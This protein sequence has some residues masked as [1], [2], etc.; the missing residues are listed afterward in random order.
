M[1][2]NPDPVLLRLGGLTIF[3]YG[4]LFTA[5]LFAT[6][7]MA[8]RY[9]VQRGLEEKHASNL[10]F[11]TIGGLFLGA[12]VLDVLVYNWS[13]FI[14]DPSI[15]LRFDRGLSS[16]GGGLGVVLAVILYAR[17]YKLDFHRVADCIMLAAVWMFAFIRTGNFINSEVVGMPTD[18]PWGVIFDATAFP[19][20]RHPSQL[21]EAAL[22]ISLTGFGTWL[23]RKHRW[24]LR[25][26]ATFYLML[27][28][29]FTVRFLLE[30]MK[31]R[32]A[33][34]PG[35][36]LNMGQLLSLP[37]AAACWGMLWLRRPMRVEPGDP[38]A[39]DPRPPG[40]KAL[41]GE[42]EPAAEKDAEEDA[43]S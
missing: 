43:E 25:K 3:W 29:Y 31:E 21:Y 30:F 14:A 42:P 10:T 24:R 9:F 22:G 13:A 38:D 1:H 28:T 2:W 11:W 33:I 6:V 12:H 26:G 8:H 19:E 7:L 17:L 27:G 20:P 15:M 23:H 4:A 39:G 34:A 16:H 5:G 18:L 41:I 37:G 36:P 35:F 32:Q 40:S